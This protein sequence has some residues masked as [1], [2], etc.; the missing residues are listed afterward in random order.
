VE[1]IDLIPSAAAYSESGDASRIGANVDSLKPWNR[2]VVLNSARIV[3]VTWEC[4]PDEYEYL[5]LRLRQNQ[6]R[7][8][9]PFEIWLILNSATR[10][11]YRAKFIPGTIQ[12]FN[13]T[14]NTVSISAQ[15]WAMPSSLDQPFPSDFADV[16]YPELP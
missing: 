14:G 11:L 8:G 2:T 12:T 9:P 4:N 5:R 10:A 6:A 1:T 13:V 16:T 3:N 7:G 15:L